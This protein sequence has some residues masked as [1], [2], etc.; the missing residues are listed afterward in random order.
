[1]L[2]AASLDSHQVSD[3]AACDIIDRILES[4]SPAILPVAT[5]AAYVLLCNFQVQFS[6]A[7]EVEFWVGAFA[8]KRPNA[9]SGVAFAFLT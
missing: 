1:M 5:E 4:L 8:V 6:G 7:D 9:E 2:L 3:E